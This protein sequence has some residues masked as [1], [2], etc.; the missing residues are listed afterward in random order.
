[1]TA[2]V[3]THVAALVLTAVAVLAPGYL[4]GA[5]G[6][7]GVTGDQA[8][9]LYLLPAGVALGGAVACRLRDAGMVRTTLAAAGAVGLVAVL[10]LLLGRHEAPVTS[11]GELLGLNAG[12]MVLF[13][14]AAWLFGRSQDSRDSSDE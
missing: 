12:F 2:G 14:G 10:G 11:V 4:A 13:L 9:L 1:M 3:R 8:D 6:V 5:V 7:M